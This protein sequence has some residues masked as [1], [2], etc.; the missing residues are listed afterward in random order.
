MDKRL[1]AAVLLLSMNLSL[2]GP[3]VRLALAD[4]QAVSLQLPAGLEVGQSGVLSA[5]LDES[6]AVSG[7]TFMVQVKK[8]LEQPEPAQWQI[9]GTDVDLAD[10]VTANWHPLRPGEY[11]IKAVANGET[12]ALAEDIQSMSVDL[13]MPTGYHMSGNVMLGPSSDPVTIRIQIQGDNGVNLAAAL[14]EGELESEFGRYGVVEERDEQGNVVEGQLRYFFDLPAG[15]YQVTAFREAYT[16]VYSQSVPVQT[17]STTPDFVGYG[18]YFVQEAPALAPGEQGPWIQM[19]PVMPTPMVD[20]E[21]TLTME[22]KVGADRAIEQDTPHLAIQL[23]AQAP[24]QP[25]QPPVPDQWI[26]LETYPDPE[27]TYSARWT[28]V[29]PGAYWLK[30][31]AT[32]NTGARVQSVTQTYAMTPPPGEEPPLEEPDRQANLHGGIHLGDGI[33]PDTVE[34][35]VYNDLITR[36]VTYAPQPDTT[37]FLTDARD[38][39]GN[40]IPNSLHYAFDLPDGAYTV[41]ALAGDLIN[42]VGVVVGSGAPHPPGLELPPRLGVAQFSYE[43]DDT[44][45]VYFDGSFISIELS[46][47]GSIPDGTAVTP[48]LKVP[49][50]EESQITL[51]LEATGNPDPIIVTGGKATVSGVLR[52]PANTQEIAGIL[53][54]QLMTTDG[55]RPL[56]ERQWLE[57]AGQ[58][59]ATF[60]HYVSRTDDPQITPDLKTIDDL[61]NIDVPLQVTRP[62]FSTI[63]F[64]AGLNLMEGTWPLAIRHAVDMRFDQKGYSIRLQSRDLPGL[65]GRGATVALFGVAKQLGLSGLTTETLSEHLIFA[66]EDA[67]GQPAPDPGAFIDLAGVDYDATGDRLTVPIHQL[68]A[69]NISRVPRLRLNMD[70]YDTRVPDAQQF[71]AWLPS[72]PPEGAEPTV[73]V[74]NA[75]GQVVTGAVDDNSIRLFVDH[76]E[77]AVEFRLNPGLAPGQYQIVVTAGDISY[78]TGFEA[79]RLGLEI[80]PE[81]DVEQGYANPVTLTVS[82]FRFDVS[83]GEWLSVGLFSAV[84]PVEGGFAEDSVPVVSVNGQLVAQVTLQPGV[85]AGWYQLVMI[86]EAN[87]RDDGNLRVQEPFNVHLLLEDGDGQPMSDVQ[88]GIRSADATPGDQGEWYGGH[89]DEHG[90]AWFNLPPGGA[91]QV[92]EV[93]TSDNH[94]VPMRLA[95][96]A[97]PE[98]GPDLELTVVVRTNTELTL[99]GP[100]GQIMPYAEMLIAPDDGTGKPVADEYAWI[101]TSTATDGTALLD[102]TPGKYHL[103]QAGLRRTNLTFTVTETGYTGSLQLPSANVQIRV[104]DQNDL[105]LPHVFVQLLPEGARPDEHDKMVWLETDS[106]GVASGTLPAGASFTVLGVAAQTTWTPVDQPLTVPSDGAEPAVL[107]IAL[108]TNVQFTL[109]DEVGL[110]MANTWLSI[111]RESD[112]TWFWASTNDAGIVSQT[113]AP[114]IYQIVELGN[115]QRHVKTSISFAVTDGD[116]FHDDLR[117]PDPSVAFRIEGDGGEPAPEVNL[118][119]RPADRADQGSASIWVRTDQAGVARIDLPRGDT[120]VLVEAATKEGVVPIGLTFTVPADGTWT[121]TIPIAPNVQAPVQNED[122]LRFAKA[123]VVIRPDDGNGRPV[124]DWTRT[125]Q[126]QTTEAGVLRIRLAPG[127]YHVTEIGDSSRYVK[128][129]LSFTVGE[130]AYTDPI[131]LPQPNVR[132]TVTG[133]G[134]APVGRAMVQIRPAD[135]RPDQHDQSIWVETDQS[136]VAR[137]QLTDGVRYR[138]VDV[139]TPQG[140]R[141]VGKEF[142]APDLQV[143]VSVATNV[144]ATLQDENGRALPY[145]MVAI[146]PDDGTGRP[147][148]MP[149]KTLFANTNGQGS[150]SINLEPGRDYHIVEIGTAQ[151]YIRTDIRFPV[152][153]S[154]GFRG[155]LS[156]PAPNL[157]VLV[158]G[159]NG[160]AWVQ[161]RPLGENQ[162]SI[163]VETNENGMASARLA[164]GTRYVVVDVGTHQG[165]T[166]VNKEITTPADT[167]LPQSPAEVQISLATNVR[168]TLR[169]ET[170]TAIG[171]AWVTIKPDDGHG[172]PVAQFDRAVFAGTNDAG[173]LTLN[174]EPGDYH[175]V[176]FGSP[177]RYVRTDIP[178]AV[179]A[180]GYT[181]NLDLPAP[182]VRVTVTGNN[183]PVAKA[184]VQIREAGAR[185]DEHEKAVWAETDGSGVLKVRLAPNT[186]YTVVDVGTSLGITMVGKEFTTP[187]SGSTTPVEVPVSLR[188][189]VLITL[190]DEFGATMPQAR[191][192]IRPVSDGGSVDGSFE[193]ALFAVTDAQGVFQI[194]LEPNRTYRIVEVATQQRYVRTEILLSVG[195]DGLTGSYSLPQP[196]VTVTVTNAGLPVARA[197]VQVR[198]ADARPGEY[199]RAVWAQTDANGLLHLQLTPGAEYLV[200]DIG[201]PQGVTPVNQPFTVPQSGDPAANVSISVTANV[202]ATLNDE[203]GAPL[204]QARVTIRPDGVAPGT[205]AARNYYGTTDANGILTANLP[206]GRYRITELGMPQRFMRTNILLDVSGGTFSGTLAMDPPNVRVAVT[207]DGAAVSRAM[208]QFRP[209][210]ARP[211]E[212]DRA[213]WAETDQNGIAGVSL[214]AGNYVLVDVGTPQ[215]ITQVSRKLTVG[216]GEVDMSVSLTANVVRTLRDESGAPMAHTW[217]SIRADGATAAEQTLHVNTDANGIFRVNLEEGWTYRIV[218]V[219][220]NARYIQTDLPLQVG[221]DNPDAQLAQADARATVVLGNDPVGFAKVAVVRASADPDAPGYWDEVIWFQADQ[222]GN[223][224]LNLAAGDYV[225]RDVETPTRRYRFTAA[226]VSFTVGAGSE[227]PVRV[228]LSEA[229]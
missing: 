67:D 136:G 11:W 93:R 14:G 95:F 15:N 131:R 90:S 103:L 38:E 97:P 137:V 135:A 19:Q 51:N 32:D 94:H 144:V 181:G 224:L 112:M 200:V 157:R 96:S 217:L 146:R 167:N 34:V 63:T 50:P 195:A 45:H 73:A 59:R 216:T 3:V 165:L 183:G 149:E 28:P 116:G 46:G 174:L 187:G 201:T 12:E 79:R 143:A 150:F 89:T 119:I 8:G 36:T 202:T 99:L 153:A 179:A 78:E 70:L 124:T 40:L 48:V 61:Y 208:V 86:N 114:G 68:T 92:V 22:V 223:V 147:V 204:R 56:T 62:E 218:E 104:T 152:A 128:T 125:I 220:N 43:D 225:M 25:P 58:R 24:D 120:F 171:R 35:R 196:N 185:P 13:G 199:Q 178:F 27:G 74:K 98:A 16:E 100:D 138:V 118:Q 4:A 65:A 121:R 173:L 53:E 188:S 75:A 41:E 91:F 205:A 10:G 60:V 197:W 142:T 134:G 210:G 186:R 160:K 31:E 151:R 209:E 140:V 115:P 87:M 71:V 170:L 163:F 69:V 212:H 219:G 29:S 207:R 203:S 215:G 107:N 105:P 133:D 39:S 110:P 9:I 113:L 176:E 130:T 184:W 82:N 221:A 172:R 101:R 7:V 47:L 127:I 66:A 102:L 229:E 64:E 30:A 193:K 182:N 57:P 141:H 18:T 109:L 21:S 222:Q 206:A 191:V 156:V 122:G 33:S 108:R 145:A 49:G 81:V 111:R 180:A 54:I 6:V 164:P 123:M 1:K 129:D 154:G 132:L 23:Q 126:G 166:R 226:P 177:Q 72:Q 106:Q 198:P 168:A 139:G 42:Q 148:D 2:A 55:A 5:V 155:T 214:P 84:G 192:T 88:V 26:P 77:P 80:V 44:D 161:I 85:P 190:R 159:Y 175:V 76:E 213:I 162:K 37:D 227:E 52:A 169:D 83:P 228:D 189:N 20:R 194:N 158:T 211:E 17:T 117:L